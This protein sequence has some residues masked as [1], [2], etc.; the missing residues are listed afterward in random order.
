MCK[1]ELDLDLDR[2]D[3]CQSPSGYCGNGVCTATGTM[4]LTSEGRYRSQ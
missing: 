3:N 1:A 2:D 4:W